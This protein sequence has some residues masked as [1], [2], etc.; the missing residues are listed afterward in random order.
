MVVFGE[1]WGSQQVVTLHKKTPHLSPAI[2]IRSPKA[3]WWPGSQNFNKLKHTCTHTHTHT[4]THTA[5]KNIQD[6]EKIQTPT[7]FLT[8]YVQ[9]PTLTTDLPKV[10]MYHMN[11][12]WKPPLGVWWSK[13][14]GLCM[15]TSH[16]LCTQKRLSPVASSKMASLQT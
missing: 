10:D 7:P 12:I 13:F 1:A 15:Y 2:R 6:T 3:W 4:H 11:D 5:L 8:D 14:R 9:V 16:R